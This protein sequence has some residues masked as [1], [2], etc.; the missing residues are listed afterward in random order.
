MESSDVSLLSFEEGMLVGVAC[1]A[2]GG[3]RSCRFRFHCGDFLAS[4]GWKLQVDVAFRPHTMPDTPEER[5]R[6][7]EEATRLLDSEFAAAAAG[8]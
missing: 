1:A 7:T 3:S 8:A 6:A 4:R 2:P 5:H